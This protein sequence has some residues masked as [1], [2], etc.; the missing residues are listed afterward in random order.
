ML[1]LIVI[2]LFFSSCFGAKQARIVGGIPT[3]MTKHP[4]QVSLERDGNHTC[5]G[6]II[7]PDWVVTAGHCVVKENSPPTKVRIN[8]LGMQS[9]QGGSVYQVSKII[10]HPEISLE[11]L[12]NN[13]IALIKV[14]TPFVYNDAVKPISIATESPSSGAAAVVTGWGVTREDTKNQ[15]DYL[16]SQLQ[17]VQ[18]IINS[19]IGC[20]LASKYLHNNMLCATAAKF[21]TGS[22]YGDSGGPLV[23]NGKL[24]GI[25][26]SGI[27]RCGSV[28]PEIYT[29]AANFREWIK[30]E[31][32]IA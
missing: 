27:F 8:L 14:S 30:S 22:C 24:V 3:E 6:S 5:G 12:G 26:S 4:F 2:S 29:N 31:T 16:P 28:F 17:E 15:R 1:S 18:I 10:V 13:D 19:G 9:Q 32:G 7:S 20:Y 21:F 25:V 23:S 11:R